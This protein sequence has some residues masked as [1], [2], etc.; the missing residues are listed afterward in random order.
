MRRR[1]FTIA[2]VV[3][4]IRPLLPLERSRQGPLAGRA[5]PGLVQRTNQQYPLPKWPDHID[6]FAL[7]RRA[8][9]L[10]SQYVADMLRRWRDSTLASLRN[11]ARAKRPTAVAAGRW[12]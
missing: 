8:R 10:R 4:V 7:E 5:Q 9:E 6:H 3:V 11:R 1:I 12:S 2:N